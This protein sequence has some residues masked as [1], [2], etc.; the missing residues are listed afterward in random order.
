MERSCS[1]LPLPEADTPPGGIVWEN[2]L[3]RSP[4]FRRAHV[5]VM[6]VANRVGVLHVCVFPNWDD[7][8]PIFGFDMIAGPSRVSGIFLDLSPVLPGVLCPSLRDAVGSAALDSFA[9]RRALPEWAN[10]FSGDMLAVRPINDDEIKHALTL[11]EWVLDGI[12][13]VLS[14]TTGRL[15]EAIVA[16]QNRYCAA[17]RQN[18]HTVRMLGSFIGPAAARRFVDQVLFPIEL[19][20]DQGAGLNSQGGPH[21]PENPD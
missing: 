13:S 2:T 4:T 11:A 20:R 10:I 8:T 18:E 19:P 6:L 16:G 9:V 1:Q 7:P 21:R 15:V 12:L 17:Q 3:L 14:A 5:E